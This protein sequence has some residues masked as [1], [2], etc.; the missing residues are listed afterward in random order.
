MKI[1]C[2]IRTLAHLTLWSAGLGF[3]L[4]VFLTQMAA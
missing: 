1:L 4:G 3:V 2:S